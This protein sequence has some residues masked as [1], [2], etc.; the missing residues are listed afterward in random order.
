MSKVK[1]KLSAL[2]LSLVIASSVGI[3]PNI[4]DATATLPTLPTQKHNLDVSVPAGATTST[5]QNAINSA[6]S[7]GGGTV[8]LA[9]GEYN[10]TAAIVLKSNVTLDGA[11]KNLT[12]LKRNAS[13]N[14]GA[15]GVLTTSTSGGV[16]NIIVKELGIDGNSFIDPDTNPDHDSITNYGALIQGPDNSNDKILFD[17]FKIKNA[18]MGL[19][20]K[21]STNVTIQNSDFNNNGGSYQYWHNMYL[22][23]VSKVLVKNNVMSFSTSGNGL[24]IS[25]SDNITIDSNNV[26]NNYFRGIRVAD[27]S[28]IDTINNNV[29]DNLTGDGIIYNSE[30]T[31]VTNFK[32]NSNTV[33]NNGGYGILVNS[34][35]S[36]GEVKS[37]INGGGNVSGFTKIDGSNVV[38][39]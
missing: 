21:G 16:S 22:R 11:G 13:N 19:H 37:N 28:Y 23:R 7:A 39:Q 9:S 3:L 6:S 17:N 2:S 38:V 5:I 24:N 34:S 1:S 20:I 27:S 25:Y 15:N 32:I 33:T 35:S 14:L 4:A 12:V 30:V 10:I 26:Y 31:G 29:H 36:N 18:T 8:T